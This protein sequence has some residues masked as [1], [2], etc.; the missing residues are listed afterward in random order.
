[1]DEL[2]A[3][4][5]RRLWHEGRLFDHSQRDQAVHVSEVAAEVARQHYE[6]LIEAYAEMA[7]AGRS[8]QLGDRRLS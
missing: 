1:M 8:K 2:E 6:P 4:I 5:Y 3:A 7:I